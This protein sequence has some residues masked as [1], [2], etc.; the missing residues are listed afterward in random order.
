MKMGRFRHGLGFL[1][2]LAVFAA[3][4]VVIMLLW[5]SVAVYL[6]A[7]PTVNFWYAAGLLLLSKLLLGGF[8]GGFHGHRCGGRHGH[9]GHRGHGRHRGFKGRG[10]CDRQGPDGEGVGAHTGF[11]S[12]MDMIR[13][14]HHRFHAMGEDE[15]R[16]KIRR[17]KERFFRDDCGCGPA[18]K[19][20]P[21]S[22]RPEDEN[23]VD[24]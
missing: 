1:I 17:H 19:V 2:F 5:N 13:E 16:E 22:D 23:R 10:G 12:H 7:V 15:R 8:K 20:S 18:R 24:E 11:D 21:V 3:A 6:F 9:H 14:M 4:T